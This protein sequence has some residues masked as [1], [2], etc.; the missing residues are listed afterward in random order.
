MV[1]LPSWA[2]RGLCPHKGAG[3]GALTLTGVGRSAQRL[4]C[5]MLQPGDNAR[6]SAAPEPAGKPQDASDE[7]VLAPSPPDPPASSPAQ[8]PDIRVRD[9]TPGG[10]AHRCPA[11]LTPGLRR[12][13]PGSWEHRSHCGSG[14]PVAGA[15]G[16]P[17]CPGPYNTKSGWGLISFSCG[18]LFCLSGYFYTLGA[19]PGMQQA[20]AS[21][22]PFP[23]M[24]PSCFPVPTN[25]GQPSGACPRPGQLLGASLLGGQPPRTTC[26][27]QDGEAS[28]VHT[29]PCLAQHGCPQVTCAVR[30]QLFGAMD[31]NT[32]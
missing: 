10:A 31:P 19:G 25:A 32:Q 11:L 13:E 22:L 8:P 24:H 6:L 21:A 28:L 20:S 18:R 1:L 14:G 9:G 12:P 30:F 23:P 2:A 29:D 4:P 15:E 16:S 5:S 27:L 7:P 26:I 3:G 17:G